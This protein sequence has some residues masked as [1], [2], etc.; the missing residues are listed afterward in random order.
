MDSST[1]QGEPRPRSRIVL[2]LIVAAIVISAGL[3]VYVVYMNRTSPETT[4]PLTI[5][6][7]DQVSLNYTG[8]F[9]YPDGRIFDTSILSIAL[10]DVLYPKSMSFSARAN[11]SYEPLSMTA[12]NY[13][14]GGTIKGFA[15]GVIGMKV[16]DHKYIY[17]DAKDAYPAD[18]TLIESHPLVQE[19]LGTELMSETEFATK[20]S[21]SPVVLSVFPHYFWGWNVT[22]IDVSAGVVTI[23]HQPTI[24]QT[25]YPFGS[26]FSEANPSGWPVIVQSY[27]PAAENGA[28]K[29]VVKHVLYE[30]DVYRV[31][32]TASDG[33][34]FIVTAFDAV[35]ETFEI[36]LNDPDTGY[37]AEIVGRALVFE[38]WIV[39]VVEG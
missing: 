20:Y 19:I 15:M 11:D 26:P 25:V 2:A 22:I 34:T 6:I 8:R 39:S 37:N 5:K 9:P 1:E 27:D 33:T 7:G 23:R 4:T 14:A 30:S 28:G 12:G 35:N 38:V 10:D 31:Q 13:G 3:V 24:G 21:R 36:H 16:G 29:V 32:G 18:P 17:V